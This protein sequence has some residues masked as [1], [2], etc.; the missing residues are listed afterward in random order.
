MAFYTP[1]IKKTY[2]FSLKTVWHDLFDKK[3]PNIFKP[4]GSQIYHGYQ[5]EGKS[6]SMYHAMVKLKKR[7][8]QSVLVSNLALRDYRPLRVSS[9]AQLLETLKTMDTTKDYLFYESYQDL[10]LLLRYCRNGEHGVII[11]ID[12]IHNYFHSHDSKSMPMWVVQVFSQ[13]RKQHL[14]ILGTVQDWEDVIRAVRKQVDN[15]I[16]CKRVGYVITQTAV[17]P[18]TAEMQFGERS[19]DVRK[20]GFFFITKNLREGTD[21]YLVINSGRE[22]IG[23][24]D[25]AVNVNM[26]DQKPLNKKRFQS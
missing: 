10:I 6:L 8:P 19:F 24:N 15:L 26:A 11:M 23:G 5:G 14:V 7:Y 9:A 3:D 13:Q 17:D 4:N 12:E 20:K 22:I 1:F 16:A 25:L 2:N 21:T 18:R